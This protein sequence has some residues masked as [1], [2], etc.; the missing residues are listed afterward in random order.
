MTM[1]GAK[2]L[3]SP[4][5]V[6]SVGG[7][8]FEAVAIPSASLKGKDVKLSYDKSQK[9]GNRLVISIGGKAYRPSLPDWMLVPISKYADSPYTACVSLFGER[10]NKSYYD[11]VYHP[12]FQNT[13]MGLRLLHADILLMDVGRFWELPRFN[14]KVVLGLGESIPGRSNWRSAALEIQSVFRRAEFRSWV[15]TDYQVP[16]RFSIDGGAFT[17]TGEPYYYFWRYDALRNDRVPKVIE[18]RSLT[19]GMKAKRSALMKLNPAVYNGLTKAMRFSAFFRFVKR[20][21]PDIW[22]SFLKQVEGAR[23]RP[24]VK[25]PTTWKRPT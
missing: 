18:V 11:I 19:E 6:G 9:D 8:A 22:S 4:S 20:N 14:G 23:I 3:G 13:L 10:T 5:F 1:Q 2:G 25:T 24:S 12:A 7:I 21:K 17:L 15:M 16:V